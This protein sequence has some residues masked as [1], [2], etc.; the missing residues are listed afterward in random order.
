MV[1]G[2]R[3]YYFRQIFHNNSDANCLAIL[4]NHKPAMGPHSVI[5]IDEK[6]ISD[7]DEASQGYT[8]ALSLNMAANFRG[9]ERKK[10]QWMRLFDSAGFVV[11]EM[12]EYTSFNDCIIA[13]APKELA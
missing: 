13:V 5:L 12:R 7:K 2:A 3:I 4:S 8:S 9:L 1:T 11:R 10:R 6:V